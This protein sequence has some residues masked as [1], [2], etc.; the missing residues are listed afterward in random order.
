MNNRLIR[1]ILEQAEQQPLARRITVYRDLLQVLPTGSDFK[2]DRENLT[3]LIEK[4]E[5]ADLQSQQILFSFP[6]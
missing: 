1:F 5:A 6:R 3:Q 4:L 2:S